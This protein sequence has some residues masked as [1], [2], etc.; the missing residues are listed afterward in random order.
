MRLGGT[1]RAVPLSELEGAST[2]QLPNSRW[3]TPSRVSVGVYTVS[4]K[5]PETSQN[6]PQDHKIVN[7]LYTNLHN[8]LVCSHV[9][10]PYDYSF[11]SRKK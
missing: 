8:T 6:T 1:E 9:L 11:G 2:A 7:V 5:S 10:K 4:A 3:V